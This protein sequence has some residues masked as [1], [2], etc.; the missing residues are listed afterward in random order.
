[1]EKN[2]MEIFD[3][4]S[5]TV[6]SAPRRQ[7]RLP[8]HVRCLV[9]GPSGCGKTNLALNLIYVYA[10]YD[11]LIIF[12]ATPHQPVY[13]ALRASFAKN[14][15]E[16]RLL[17]TLDESELENLDPTLR[18]MVVF[19]DVLLHKQRVIQS[20]FS[21]GR[22]LNVVCCCYLVQTY[23]KVPA[24]LIRD[25]ANVIVLFPQND[26]NLSMVHRDHCSAD[27]TFSELKDLC[28]DCWRRPYGFLTID[29]SSSQRY[30]SCTL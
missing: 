25:N 11:R 4:I 15:Q 6:G 9:A 19:D 18:H 14:E 29:K 13:E 1:M 21:Q 20:M 5:K 3:L 8:Q 17:F 12:T 16:H 10:D 26:R 28:L 23:T 7:N 27:L 22:H 30:K 2:G 24:A